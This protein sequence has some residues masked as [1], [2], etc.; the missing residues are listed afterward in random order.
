MSPMTRLPL[1]I[2]HALL[3]FLRRQP[4]HGYEIHQ[5]LSMPGGLGLVWRLKQSQLYALLA[6]LEQ[7]GYI[8]AQVE[9]QGSRPPRKVFRLTDA[10]RDSFLAWLQTPVSRG[11]QMRVDF[12]A[13]LYFARREGPVMAARVIEQQRAACNTWLATLRARAES[14]PDEHSFESLVYQY[15]I[16]QMEADLAWLDVCRQALPGGDE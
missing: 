10:G 1:T 8:T 16:H 15:R 12:L 5:Q 2:E 11:R 4:M 14:L 13:K 6:R 7:D 9:P 3:G